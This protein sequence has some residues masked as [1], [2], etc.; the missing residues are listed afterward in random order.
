MK[1]YSMGSSL[2]SWCRSLVV[3][4]VAMVLA[5]AIPMTAL[6]GGSVNCS[7]Y[8][9]LYTFG[10]STND[11]YHHVEGLPST[12]NL[13]PGYKSVHWGYHSGWKNWNVTGDGVTSESASCIPS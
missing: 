13:G 11:Q 9:R 2:R 4:A 10:N 8:G 3:S 5:L 12:G 6:A 1:G 7:Q